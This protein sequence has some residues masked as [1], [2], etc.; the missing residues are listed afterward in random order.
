MGGEEAAVLGVPAGVWWAGT[1]LQDTQ[2]VG[3]ALSSPPCGCPDPD[4]PTALHIA[5]RVCESK[6]HTKKACR[7]AHAIPA[8]RLPVATAPATAMTPAG[9]PP[10]S[11]AT[12]HSPHVPPATPGQFQPQG[13]RTC[14]SHCQECSDLTS[15]CFGLLLHHM[16]C[17]KICSICTKFYEQASSLLG[18]GPRPGR[19]LRWS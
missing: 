16:G 11:P 5:A 15:L 3:P 17:R 19:G 14:H 7:T 12:G 18:S 6:T 2:L 8:Q 13:L 1:G 4:E 10:P 9:S